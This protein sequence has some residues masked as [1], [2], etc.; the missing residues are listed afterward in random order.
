MLSNTNFNNKIFLQP[1]SAKEALY[2]H[3][4]AEQAFL[5]YLRLL[6]IFLAVLAYLIFVDSDLAARLALRTIKQVS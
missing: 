5:S 6:V 1:P 3:S 2:F 4:L